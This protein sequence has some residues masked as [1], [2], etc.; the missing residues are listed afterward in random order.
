[1]H[2]IPLLLFSIVFLPTIALASFPDVPTNHPNR[3]AI[4]YVQAQKI[5]GGYPD[6]TYQPN[7]T[8]NRAEFAKIL[9]ESIPDAELGIGVCPME[10][11]DFTTFSDVRG[12]WFWIYV[13]MQQGRSI[14]QGYSDGTFRPASN[15]NF[16][17][18]AKMIYRSLHL[19]RRGLWVSEDPASDPWFRFYVE[20][21]ASANAIPVSIASF[22]KHITR[23]EMAEI[24][25]RLK[26]GNNDKPSRTYKELALSGGTMPV[27]LYFTNR[28]VLEV[29][30]CSAVLPTT[31]VI[32]KTSA[33]ADAALREL[34]GGV[35]ERERAQ[36]LTSSFDVFERT[37]LS[38]YKGISIAYG[39][40][41]VKFDAAAMAYLNGAACMQMSVK[42]P[43]E[44]TL[45]QFPSIK[46]V[47]YSVDGEIV[48][49]WDA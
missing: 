9:E 33:V 28:A 21:L 12:E 43:M 31:R 37:L 23:G 19:D 24:I 38:S 40:A 48:T 6:G 1:M 34:F 42:A 45:L 49:E 20:A 39:V 18:A 3:E 46:K 13:C 11:E 5:V 29:S 32:P 17:E 47:Q 10:P 30:D 41:T 7:K 14:V 25:Y 22:D 2:L 26:T 4:E 27:T 16:G 35:T 15:I 36:G 8:I 44:R